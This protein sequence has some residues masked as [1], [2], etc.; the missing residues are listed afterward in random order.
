MVISKR[1]EEVEIKQR[2][3]YCSTRLVVGENT[4]STNV[5]IRKKRNDNWREEE[6]LTE[7]KM[8]PASQGTYRV[9]FDCNNDRFDQ[10]ITKIVTPVLLETNGPWSIKNKRDQNAGFKY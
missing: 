1:F 4:T 9:G 7:N 10:Q 8:N 3:P 5:G 2:K 6:G